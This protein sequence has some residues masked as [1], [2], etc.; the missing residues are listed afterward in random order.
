MGTHGVIISRGP[1]HHGVFLP[2]VAD[3][4]GWTKEEFLSQLCVQK[5]GLPANAWK[6]PETTIE[7]FKADVFSEADIN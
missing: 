4:T 7:I 2:Q 3:T 6:D 5:A 1:G